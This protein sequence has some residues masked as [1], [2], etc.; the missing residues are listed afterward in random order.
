[1][2]KAGDFAAKMNAKTKQ[3]KDKDYQKR[4]VQ[5]L[6]Q[7]MR[8]TKGGFTLQCIQEFIDVVKPDAL[9]DLSVLPYYSKFGNRASVKSKRDCLMAIISHTIQVYWEYCGGKTTQVKLLDAIKKL[10]ETTKAYPE[11]IVKGQVKGGYWLEV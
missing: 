9:F 5:D 7:L 8:K 10:E 2:S 4:I 3:A 6:R 1:M 11:V